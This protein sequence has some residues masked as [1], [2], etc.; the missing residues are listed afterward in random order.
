MASH[1]TLTTV[2]MGIGFQQTC[3]AKSDLFQKPSHTF[4]LLAIR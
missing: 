4:D 2:H 1:A 3:G